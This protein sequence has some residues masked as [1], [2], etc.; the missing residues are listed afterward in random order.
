[1]PAFKATNFTLST[2]FFSYIYLTDFIVAFPLS[3]NWIYFL[4]S[5]MICNNF[6]CNHCCLEMICLTFKYL[7]VVRKYD[8]KEILLSLIKGGGERK[9]FII[10]QTLNQNI[11]QIT[12]NPLRNCK[13]RKTERNYV[14]YN[15][16]VTTHYL[17]TVKINSN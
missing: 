7:E 9:H 12:V 15:Q 5:I 3:F 17:D 11:I 13:D 16:A 10:V 4:I 14:F 2:A 6:I 1:M 8:Y